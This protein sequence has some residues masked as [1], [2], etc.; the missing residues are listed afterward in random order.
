MWEK[1]LAYCN[2]GYGEY[3]NFEEAQEA[4]KKDS[5]CAAIYDHSCS[6]TEDY[7]LCPF[8]HTEKSSSWSC[9]YIK[10]AG[11]VIFEIIKINIL[12]RY[13]FYVARS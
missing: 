4:C 9:L 2:G 8:G 13:I 5:N 1:T 3:N 12:Q 11:T 10:G 7:Y 6:S